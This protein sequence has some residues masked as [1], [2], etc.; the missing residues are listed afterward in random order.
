MNL[1]TIDLYTEAKMRQE[2]RWGEAE[3]LRLAGL[4]KPEPQSRH[5]GT[6]TR[7]LLWLRARLVAPGAWLQM[8]QDEG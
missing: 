1:Y 8:Q 4:L 7:F 5:A 3:M 6:G 2:A